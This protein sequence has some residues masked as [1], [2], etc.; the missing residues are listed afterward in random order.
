MKSH[1]LYMNYGMKPPVTLPLLGSAKHTSPSKAQVLSLNLKG[2]NY[3]ACVG[4]MYIIRINHRIETSL[5][6]ELV[7]A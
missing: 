2:F 7:C 4:M 6:Y 5:F 3:E 1:A